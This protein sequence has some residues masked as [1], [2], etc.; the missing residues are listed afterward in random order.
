MI[1]MQCESGKT[2]CMFILQKNVYLKN[3][4]AYENSINVVFFYIL[5][6]EDFVTDM[7][8]LYIT[9]FSSKIQTNQKETQKR[10]KSLFFHKKR[11]VNNHKSKNVLQGFAEQNPIS[12][13]RN[14]HWRNGLLLSWLIQSRYKSRLF[15]LQVFFTF[16][17]KKF[18]DKFTAENSCT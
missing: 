14:S 16:F 11:N 8:N 17:R 12:T 10:L 18:F 4:A 9:N 7:R 1:L 2:Y 3:V 5:E 15:G 13:F 6:F